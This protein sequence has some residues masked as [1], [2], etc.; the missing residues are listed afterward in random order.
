MEEQ[1]RQ[2][3]AA[4]ESTREATQNEIEQSYA[5]RLQALDEENQRV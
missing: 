4:I 1:L 5:Q 2:S 3:R